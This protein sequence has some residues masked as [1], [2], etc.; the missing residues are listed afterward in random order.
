M[1]DETTPTL[2]PSP[3]TTDPIEMAHE[4]AALTWDLKG[5]N[6]TV[7]D[8]R[9]LVSYTDCI[10]ITT[11]TSERQLMAL[12]R[13]ANT[14][15]RRMGYRPLH[16]EGMDGARWALLDF[17]D[18]ILHIFMEDARAEYNLEGMWT[19]APR[20]TFE[21]APAELYGHFELDRFADSPWA[22]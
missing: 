5:L 10:V 20:V 11:A 16:S 6:T 22:D 18:V 2:T 3:P 8:L 13:H 15:L 9:G 21:D 1:T 19:A 12:A 7:I 4:V 14:E 17:G